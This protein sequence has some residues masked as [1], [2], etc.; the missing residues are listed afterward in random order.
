MPTYNEAENVKRIIPALL[1]ALERE[2]WDAVVL[3]VDDASPDGTADVAEE[4]GRETG[5]G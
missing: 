5:G 3:V 1:D 2:G 4:L